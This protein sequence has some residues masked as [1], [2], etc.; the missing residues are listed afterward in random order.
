MRE[1][2]SPRVCPVG[3]GHGTLAGLLGR[4]AL[5]PFEAPDFPKL[6][7]DSFRSAGGGGSVYGAYIKRSAI[8]GVLLFLHVTTLE[9]QP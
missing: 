5:K 2:I 7:P 9:T 6:L 3:E 1:G 4:P 8:C